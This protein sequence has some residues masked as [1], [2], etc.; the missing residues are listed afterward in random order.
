M[1]NIYYIKRNDTERVIQTTLT[2]NEGAVDL[3]GATVK[4]IMRKKSLGP[5]AEPKVES[6]ATVESAVDGVVR[7]Q[8][9]PGDTDTTGVYNAEWEVTWPGSK[10]DTY[11]NNDYNIV[12]VVAD[13]NP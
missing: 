13:L 4:F 1:A 7:Y 2:F 6:A 9:V 8:W 12:N 3:T 10:T 11:P 5:N